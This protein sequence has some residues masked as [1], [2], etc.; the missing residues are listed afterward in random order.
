MKF[1]CLPNS[2]NSCGKSKHQNLSKKSILAFSNKV[3]GF[4]IK[5]LV[6]TGKT[7]GFTMRYKH[8]RI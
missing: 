1:T 3:K 2:L 6:V 5:E 8:R 7:A 4:D